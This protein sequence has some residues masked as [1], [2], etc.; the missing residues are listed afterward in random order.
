MV[1]DILN[2]EREVEKQKVRGGKNVGVFVRLFVKIILGISANSDVWF[3]K[4]RGSLK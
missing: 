2:M 3:R 4:E 1:A